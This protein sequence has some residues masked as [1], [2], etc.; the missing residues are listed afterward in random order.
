[1]FWTLRW[2]DVPLGVQSK[3]QACQPAELAFGVLSHTP[4]HL[5]LGRESLTFHPQQ[6]AKGHLVPVL[7]LREPA[8]AFCMEV[9]PVSFCY[10][11]SSTHGTD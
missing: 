6:R 11:S 1:M 10:L 5:H 9:S 2:A 3:P 8:D 7:H 4:V